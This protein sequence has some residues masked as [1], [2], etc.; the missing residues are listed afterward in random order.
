MQVPKIREKEIVRL[1]QKEIKELLKEAE[2]G[3]GLSPRQKV[4]RLRW[5][6]Q[7]VPEIPSGAVL[8]H[9]FFSQKQN[10]NT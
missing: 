9:L 3:A 8:L 4:F 1:N 5:W 7:P 6:I 2:S 10:R